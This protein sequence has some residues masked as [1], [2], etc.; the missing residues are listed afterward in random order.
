MSQLLRDQG[1][2][3][4]VGGAVFLASLSEQVGFAT[5]ADYYAHLVLTDSWRREYRQVLLQLSHAL[6]QDQTA[7]P[8]DLMTLLSFK[9]VELEASCPGSYSQKPRLIS[10][11]ELLAMEFPEQSELIGGGIWPAGTGLMIPGKAEPARA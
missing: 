10:L 7:R 3:D 11:E 2:L 8:D 1:Q 5:N 4:S 9:L 6:E